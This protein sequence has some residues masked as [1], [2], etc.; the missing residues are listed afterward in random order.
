MKFTSPRKFILNF[1]FQLFSIC[2]SGVVLR[3]F[4]YTQFLWNPI[5]IMKFNFFNIA[6]IGIAV[7]FPP[8]FLSIL[9]IFSFCIHILIL[10]KWIIYSRDNNKNCFIYKYTLK[11]W[12]SQSMEKGRVVSV[13]KMTFLHFF[14]LNWNRIQKWENISLYSAR[15]IVCIKFPFE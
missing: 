9:G 4:F 6:V 7:V 13:W 8:S 10:R 11:W 3:L 12:I 15:I 1:D 14:F 5:E 2:Y